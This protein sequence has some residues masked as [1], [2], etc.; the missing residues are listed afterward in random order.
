MKKTCAALLALAA[1][2]SL[3]GFAAAD[4][5]WGPGAA[6]LFTL[7]RPVFWAVIALVVAT[8]LLIRRNGKNR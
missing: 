6:V 8:I 3:T 7:T 2:L 5:V 4:V 1:A